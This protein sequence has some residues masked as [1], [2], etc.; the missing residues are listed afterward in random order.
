M[1]QH[2]LLSQLREL[3]DDE[4]LDAKEAAHAVILREIGDRPHRDAFTGVNVSDYPRWARVMVGVLLMT[5]FLSAA[6]PSLFRLYKAGRDAHLE[7]SSVEW[8]AAIVGVSTFMLA[9][10]I[11]ITS[12]LSASIFFRG[13]ARAWFAVPVVLGLAMAFVGNWTVVQPNTV[14]EWLE[15]L[16]PPLTVVFVSFIGERLVLDGMKQAHADEAA[17]QT[18]MSEWQSATRDVEGHPRWTPVYAR[19]L[20]GALRTVNSKGTGAKARRELMDGLPR[21]A[22]ARLVRRELDI[23]GGAWLTEATP[24]NFEVKTVHPSTEGK[25]PHS[26]PTVPALAATANIKTMPSVNGHTEHVK[27]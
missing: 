16:V 26:G 1:Q 8:Q 4:R 11:I 5:V 7:H 25:V 6:A 20:I 27:N 18:A 13:R 9:E 17:Y 23:E 19:A 2:E 15:T 12:T 14:F 10:F 3:T 21:G 24:D 22:W